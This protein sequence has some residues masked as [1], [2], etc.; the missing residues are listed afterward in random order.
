[1]EEIDI[2]QRIAGWVCNYKGDECLEDKSG[3][4]DSVNR[5]DPACR[6]GRNREWAAQGGPLKGGALLESPR[7]FV[8]VS[9]CLRQRE[10]QMTSPDMGRSS[11]G[12]LSG[13]GGGGV[14]KQPRW[15]VARS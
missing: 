12:F 14:G 4:C 2:R 11:A 13:V 5:G 3:L 9:G 8:G 1:M 15:T 7:G 6:G 10:L